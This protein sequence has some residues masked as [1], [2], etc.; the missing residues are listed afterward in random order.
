MKLTRY[1]KREV[2]R[3]AKNLN[4]PTSFWLMAGG[5]AMAWTLSSAS[6]FVTIY[7]TL[8]FG[9][10]PV[11]Y[12]AGR[13][14]LRTKKFPFES[15][16]ILHVWNDAKDRISRLEAA[17]REQKK[18]LGV[19]MSDILTTVR[20]VHQS[21]FNALRNADDLADELTK[22]E[23]S[24]GPIANAPPAAP[25]AGSGPE[26]NRLLQIAEKQR[27]EYLKTHN[28]L[29]DSVSRT[30]AEARVF[31]NTLDNVRIRLLGY[32]MV[33]M[34]DDFGREEFLHSLTEVKTSLDSMDKSLGEINLDPFG[35]YTNK[36][37]I[38]KES[39]AIPEEPQR[40]TQ[41]EN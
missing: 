38:Q 29:H 31:V 35:L 32:R 33:N 12:W 36:F 4:D 24:I 2:K 23:R 5:F 15:T 34:S 27:A 30:I 7:P 25:I 20:R 1:Q 17:I 11:L 37:S 26:T 14:Y 39:A 13:A 9:L 22:S 18:V 41:E 21:L 3:F 16:Q 8:F 19:D 28:S 40:Q 10:V 6:R